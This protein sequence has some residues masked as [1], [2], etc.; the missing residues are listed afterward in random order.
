ML[1]KIPERKSIFV[2][3]LTEKQLS[4]RMYVSVKGL[5]MPQSGVGSMQGQDTRNMPSVVCAS[6]MNKSLDPTQI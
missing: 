5:K 3:V 1:D 6:S 2:K 4:E